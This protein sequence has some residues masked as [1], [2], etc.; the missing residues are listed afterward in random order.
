M[1]IVQQILFLILAVAAI[2]VFVK[3]A[4]FIRKNINLGREEAMESHPDR[5]RNVLLMA[6]WTKAHVR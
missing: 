5:W 6:F 1:Q 3:K 2:W 4:G